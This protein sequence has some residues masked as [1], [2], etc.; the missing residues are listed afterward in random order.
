MRCSPPP[1]DTAY[2]GTTRSPGHASSGSAQVGGGLEA[3]GQKIGVPRA[4]PSGGRDGLPQGVC[5][6]RAHHFFGSRTPG[7]RGFVDT[8]RESPASRV[9]APR[10]RPT[11]GVHRPKSIPAPAEALR[12]VCTTGPVEQPASAP[13]GA[14]EQG[15]ARPRRNQGSGAGTPIA[16]VMSNRPEALGNTGPDTACVRPLAQN[17]GP[18]RD[19]RGPPCGAPKLPT[20]VPRVG[21]G[22]PNRSRGWAAPR[23]PSRRRWRDRAGCW[24]RA[25]S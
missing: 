11:P 16:C 20:S 5:R 25:R 10:C 15:P 24:P 23:T 6:C 2:G 22:P 18:R 21:R 8:G 19:R 1:W 4:G 12:H 14:P 13:G 17:G 7:A 3:C 9:V